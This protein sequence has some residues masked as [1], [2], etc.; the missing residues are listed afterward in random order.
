MRGKIG[1]LKETNDCAVRAAANATGF[2]Y[3]MVHAA[4]RHHGRSDNKGAMTSTIA[5][6]YAEL[7]LKLEGVFGTSA[8][9]RFDLA[10]MR[11]VF[12]K[13]SVKHYAGM[14]LE[15]FIRGNLKGSFVCCTN[16]HAFAVIDGKLIDHTPLA[17]GI[18][19]TFIFR[20]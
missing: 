10:T 2:D 7:G 5:K 3:E 13:D 18:R 1:F 11:S 14:T 6:A 20:A 9:A 17:A 12:G 16:N 8:S 19:I 4:L 15:R